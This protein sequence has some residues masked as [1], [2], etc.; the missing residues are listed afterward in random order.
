MQPSAL[1]ID[2][3]TLRMI[4][5]TLRKIRGEHLNATQCI[6]DRSRYIA[7]DPVCIP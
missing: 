1:K 5:S 7:N 3:T 2:R 6:E 4:L